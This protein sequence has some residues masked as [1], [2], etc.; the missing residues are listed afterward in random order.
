MPD[1]IVERDQPALHLES[2]GAA[3]STR[4]RLVDDGHF[5]CLLGH[6]PR[7][8]RVWRGSKSGFGSVAGDG[9]AACFHHR[10]R[11]PRPCPALV[12]DR[13]ELGTGRDGRHRRIG[14]RDRATLRFNIA[15]GEKLLSSGH[16][17]RAVVGVERVAR[18]L[19]GLAYMIS[20]GFTCGCSCCFCCKRSVSKARR[21]AVF[22]RQ[23][24]WS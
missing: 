13:R 21:P 24:S 5:R 15:H 12:C 7:C 3:S 11:L 4:D 2:C 17:P 10:E 1:C 9:N 14:L 8:V 23:G 16:P 18:F 20:V 6:R 22:S 19:L